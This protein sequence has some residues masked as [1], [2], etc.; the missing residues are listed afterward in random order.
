MTHGHNETFLSFRTDRN[1][2]D[3]KAE[4]RTQIPYTAR[5]ETSRRYETSDEGIESRRSRNEASP[6]NRLKRQLPGSVETERTRLVSCFLVL[7]QRANSVIGMRASRA[8]L[9]TPDTCGPG[10]RTR[11][12]IEI[13]L[14]TALMPERIAAHGRRP[15]PRL[16]CQDTSTKSN[17]HIFSCDVL[18]LPC[19]HCLATLYPTTLFPAR[20]SRTL[21]SIFLLNLMVRC[22]ATSNGVLCGTRTCKI[23][24]QVRVRANRC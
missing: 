21:V 10:Q 7:S 20:S 3:T 17:D 2:S 22:N 15:Q 4:H 6:K 5:F 11:F 1:D 12:M 23:Y 13:T 9:L 24:R 14:P 16:I 18:R 19:F 8:N